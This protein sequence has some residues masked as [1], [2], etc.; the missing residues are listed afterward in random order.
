MLD[1]RLLASRKFVGLNTE[2]YFTIGFGYTIQHSGK[3]HAIFGFGG[4]PAFERDLGDVTSSYWVHSLGIATRTS[5]SEPFS[6]DVSVKYV[7]DYTN[8]FTVAVSAGIA[9]AIFQ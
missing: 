6:L 1:A 5:I 7:T 3:I 4:V 9:Y 8:N 2:L